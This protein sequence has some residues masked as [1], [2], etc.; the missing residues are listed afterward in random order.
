MAAAVKLRADYSVVDLRRL[1]AGSKHAIQ[2]RWFEGLFPM[3]PLSPLLLKT[4]CRD[5][6]LVVKGR[7]FGACAVFVNRLQWR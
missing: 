3:K 6:C 4:S 2:S 1:A 5:D 7:Y